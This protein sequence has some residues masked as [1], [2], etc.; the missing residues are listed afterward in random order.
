MSDTLGSPMFSLPVAHVKR[1]AG[2]PLVK[3][4]SR[5]VLAIILTYV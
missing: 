2:I 3:D 1:G 5:A 4:S